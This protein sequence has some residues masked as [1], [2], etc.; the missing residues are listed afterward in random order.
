MLNAHI[1]QLLNYEKCISHGSMIVY[2]LVI[3]AIAIPHVVL[4]IH[5]CTNILISLLSNDRLLAYYK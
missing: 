4:Y 3:I 5:A 2:K 1:L